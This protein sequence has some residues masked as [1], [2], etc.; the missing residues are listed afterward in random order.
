MILPLGHEQTSVR[1]LPWVTF[2]IMGVCCVAYVLTATGVQRAERGLLE[3]ARE[4]QQYF[5]EHPYLELDN[6]LKQRMGP[7]EVE[8]LEVVLE[9]TRSMGPKP[10][11]DPNELRRQQIEF[12]SLVTELF[13]A[14]EQSPYYTWGLVPA[15]PSL[16]GLITHQFM[17]VGFW[18][19]FGNLFM[20]YLVGP[21]VED[22]WG[23]PLFGAF[24]L[25]AGVV[26]ALFFVARYPN[27]DGPLIGASGAIAGVMGAF[28]VRYWSTRIRF[29][30]WFF[31]VLV[32]TFSAPA[33]LMLPLWF[34]KELVFAHVGDVVA[35]QSG[36]GG[37]AYWAHV[38]GFGFGAVTALVISY[39][40]VEDRFIHGSIESKITLMDNV[41]V[42]Q[43]LDAVS[44]GRLDEG[45]ARLDEELRRDPANVDAALARLHVAERLGDARS[46]IPGLLAALDYSARAGD[47]ELLATHWQS[48]PAIDPEFVVAP[49]T[50]LRIADC[51]AA[52]GFGGMA[53]DAVSRSVTQLDGTTPVGVLLRLARLALSLEAAGSLVLV[54]AAL[55]HPDIPVEAA[56]EMRRLREQ[57]PPTP[58]PEAPSPA[59]DEPVADD[60]IPIEVAP[61]IDSSGRPRTLQVMEGVPVAFDG[62]ALSVEVRGQR[63][64]LSLTEVEGLA[65][66]GIQPPDGK[67]FLVV[68]LLLDSV[69][70][71]RPSLR[72]LRLVSSSFD[73]RTLV[74]GDKPMVA[75][76]VLLDRIARVSEA[77]PLPDADSAVGNPFKTYPSLADYEREVLGAGPG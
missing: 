61:M 73:P 34:A 70:V 10:P 22:V 74:G 32:G 24:Y 20:L 44:A 69:L 8:Q 39:F 29:F 51:L 1:R 17:H 75:F 35:S 60:R 4:V 76:R 13:E 53:A 27:F 47:A 6:R 41:G 15:E 65:V 59:R 54:D 33:W 63:R 46:A 55:A 62:D 9:V 56:I 67:P 68:D 50:A 36:G 26:A 38:A 58:P 3:T 57:A 66:G 28:L 12:E 42:E 30:Y 52:S 31:F 77:L 71:E 64:R 5:L 19:L 11:S 48:L 23:R 45:A 18:H 7:A 43:A 16:H 25:V 40:R 2:A 37:V 72:V 14:R 21:F 49:V